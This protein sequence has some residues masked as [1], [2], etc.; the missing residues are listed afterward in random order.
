MVSIDKR[1]M[2]ILNPNSWCWQKERLKDTFWEWATF[3]WDMFDSSLLFFHSWNSKDVFVVFLTWNLSTSN[4][5]Y[6]GSHLPCE[7]TR[8]QSASVNVWISLTHIWNP[9][10]QFRIVAATPKLQ[11]YSLTFISSYFW[12]HFG[13]SL[14]RLRIFLLLCLLSENLKPLALQQATPNF[15][16]FVLIFRPQISEL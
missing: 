16:I 12:S 13:E 6:E 9:N 5:D 11:F 10:L 15:E 8:P 1:W 7:V 14:G 2:R 4:F 3:W